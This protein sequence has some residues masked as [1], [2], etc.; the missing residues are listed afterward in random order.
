M[1]PAQQNYR[2]RLLATIHQHI[3][4]KE[5]KA[6]GVWSDYLFGRWGVESSRDLSLEELKNLL[7]ILNGRTANIVRDEKRRPKPIETK[8]EKPKEFHARATKAQI[9]KIMTLWQT[10]SDLKDA[11]SLKRFI[12]R[13]IGIYPLHL[14]S[15]ERSDATKVILAIEKL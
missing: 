3:R 1:T 12:K 7:D 5:M 11:D 2:K 4:M 14:E 8:A 10:H 15:L 9:G 13:V 6:Q